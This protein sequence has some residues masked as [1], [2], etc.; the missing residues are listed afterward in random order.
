MV[1]FFLLIGLF[2]SAFAQND[3]TG[4]W[5]PSKTV[6][7]KRVTAISIGA[8]SAYAISMTGLYF[9]WYQGNG[10]QSFTLFNDNREWL[11]MD[12][13]G[14]VISSYYI[15]RYSIDLMKWAGIER[16]KAIWLGGSIGSVI[17][18]TVE[19]FDGFSK[20]YGFSWGDILANST[21]SILITTQMLVWNEQRIIFRYSFMN[22]PEWKLRKDLLGS[23]LG[24]R[25]IKDYNSITYWLS[26]NIHS[27]LRQESRFPRWLNVAFGYGANGML[28][29]MYNPSSHN[30]IDLPQME[31]YRQYYF[32]LDVQ[33]SKIKTK[34]KILK[35]FFLAFDIIKFPLPALEYNRIHGFGI[36]PFN[37]H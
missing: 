30:G 36:Y 4:F 13:A 22:S 7:R 34:S 2:T 18:G 9:A 31:R 6:N 32:S 3:S 5:I 24:E 25:F 20:E 33:L 10:S 21:G 28:G 8:G 37:N 23:N 27:F 35:T 16:R 29:G 19:V 17:L 14:H 11:Q 12:K 15:G 26:V 1:F